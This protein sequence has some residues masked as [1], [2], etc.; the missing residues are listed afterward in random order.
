MSHRPADRGMRATPARSGPRAWM[1]LALAAGCAGSS[2]PPATDHVPVDFTI[3][4]LEVHVASG[5]AEMAG[6]VLTFYLTDQPDGCLAVTYTPVGRA[7]ILSLGVAAAADGTT[8]ATVVPP[9]PAPAPG[10]AVGSLRR[11]IG[12]VPDAILDATDG[13]VSW[14]T[15]ADGSVT[16]ES[17]DV[18]FAGAAGRLTTGGLTIPGC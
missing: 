14:M 11:T 10:E 1:A 15:N 16:I 13:S 5:A 6:S 2:T 17:L 7:T 12:G 18:G 3:G 8:R 9:K 4:G